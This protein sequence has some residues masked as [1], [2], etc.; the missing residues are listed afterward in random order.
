MLALRSTQS[1]SLHAS[2]AQRIAPTAVRYAERCHARAMAGLDEFEREHRVSVAL[3]RGWS[4]GLRS[5]RARI[6]FVGLMLELGPDFDRHPAFIEKLCEPIVD[7]D[8]DR[9]MRRLW[10]DVSDEAWL[11][12]WSAPEEDGWARREALPTTAMGFIS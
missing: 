7:G 5:D 8:E 1:D 2:W 12:A 6:G 9:F 10:D 11:E 4:Y 3:D